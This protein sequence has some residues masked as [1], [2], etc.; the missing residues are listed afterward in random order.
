MACPGI[1]K[2]GRAC[3]FTPQKGKAHCYH[4]DPALR[5][6]RRSHARSRRTAP[7]AP[8]TDLL[9]LEGQQKWLA[10]VVRDTWLATDRSIHPQRAAAVV[11]A[12]KTLFQLTLLLE[13]R[14]AGRNPHGATPGGPSLAEILAHAS[15]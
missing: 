5:E 2:D 8:P 15:N 10:T 14:N 1:Q 6:T 9:T 3:R 11:Q 4:H 7:I 13:Q 12:L